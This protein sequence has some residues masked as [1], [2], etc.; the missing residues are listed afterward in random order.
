MPVG[1]KV[2]LLALA[3][4]DDLGA[5]VIIA[6]FYTSHLS[7]PVLAIA[8]VGVMVLAY[9]NYRGVTR[10][11]FYVLTGVVVWVCVLKSGV[12]ATLAGVVVALFLPL[13]SKN[14]DQPSPMKQVEHGLSPW[15]AFGVVPIFAFANAGV[16]LHNLSLA[17]L[18]GGVPLGIALG[19]F[20]GKQLGIMSSIWLTVR[21]GI[22]RLPDRVAG[23]QRLGR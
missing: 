18:V 22:A 23:S 9:L 7:L 16:T 20:L 1:L 21:L 6:A 19:L 3:I 4:I 13:R 5:I 8:A 10:T 17:D 11:S 2:F 15:V 12:H 14:K